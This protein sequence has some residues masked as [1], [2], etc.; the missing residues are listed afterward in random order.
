MSTA[1]EGPVHHH[2]TWFWDEESYELF[3]KDRFVKRPL[4]I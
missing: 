2:L 3:L 4:R 1:T